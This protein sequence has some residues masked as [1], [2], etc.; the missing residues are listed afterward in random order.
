MEIFCC[1]FTDCDQMTKK[2]KKKSQLTFA[3]FAK[4][5]S[6][7]HYFIYYFIALPW[8]IWTS[9]NYQR[10]APVQAS[11]L[12]WFGDARDNTEHLFKEKISHTFF[13]LIVQ[14]SSHKTVKLHKKTDDAHSCCETFWR[15]VSECC[16]TNS[17]SPVRYHLDMFNVFQKAII[18]ENR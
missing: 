17:H 2:K 9:N 3:R 14:N 4:V 1:S 13:F 11:P 16:S 15:C 10:R 7:A 6:C 12:R 5:L 8:P 18:M